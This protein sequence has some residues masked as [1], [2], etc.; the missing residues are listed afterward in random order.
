MNVAEN[1]GF[2][3]IGNGNT[4]HVTNLVDGLQEGLEQGG[5]DG[6][7]LKHDR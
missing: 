1:S 7:K 6:V 2:L 4:I 5:A 3:R